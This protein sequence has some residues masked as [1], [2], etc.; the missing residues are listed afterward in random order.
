MKNKKMDIIVVFLIFIGIIG[1]YSS[2]KIQEPPQSCTITTISIGEKILFGNNE[3]FSLKGTGLWFVPSSETTYGFIGFGYLGNWHPSDRFTQGGM[4]EMGLS[5][6]A[7]ALSGASINRKPNLDRAKLDFFPSVLKQCA[8]VNETIEWFKSHNFGSTARGQYHFADANGDAVI[9]SAGKDGEWAFTTN[10]D[11][12]YLLSTNFNVVNP[13]NGWYPCWRYN[14]AEQHLD[15]FTHEENVTV[16]NLREIMAATVQDGKYSTQYINIFNPKTLDI[17]VWHRSNYSKTLELN[18]A[19]EL[20]GLEKTEYHKIPVLLG[21]SDWFFPPQFPTFVA[22]GIGIVGL[23]VYIGLKIIKKRNAKKKQ[24]ENHNN[25][26][27][28][29]SKE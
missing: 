17:Y 25:K 6:D 18:L 23:I 5:C 29:K 15:N 16:S 28:N 3:D 11:S 26:N 19:D 4:N 2:S 1:Y 14:T 24:K 20:Q 22:I 9:I 21:G 7:N 10:E 27:I 13:E 12:N 8:T